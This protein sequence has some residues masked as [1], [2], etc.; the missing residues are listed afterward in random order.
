MTIYIAKHYW[1]DGETATWEC[2]P[3]IDKNLF[4]YL[5]ENYS[6]LIKD[7]PKN[8]QVS[9]RFI[10]LCYEET[11]DTFG[12]NITNVTFFVM[13][14]Q[15]SIDFCSSVYSNLEITIKE[16]KIKT[17]I[18]LG[19]IFLSLVG[20]YNYFPNANT[21]SRSKIVP[22]EINASDINNDEVHRLT[23]KIKKDEKIKEMFNQK[24]ALKL[25]E[26]NMTIRSKRDFDKINKIWMDI[27]PKLKEKLRLLS[28]ENRDKISNLKKTI[29]TYS[30]IFRNGVKCTLS[31]EKS[32]SQILVKT[33]HEKEYTYNKHKFEINDIELIKL[34]HNE[35]LF[36][37]IASDYR[38]KIK[39]IN[40]GDSNGN[41]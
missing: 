25:N 23:I 16:S 27:K 40:T 4:K 7:K 35:V 18:L 8:I 3:K 9:K 28:D 2:H 14:K 19:V 36:K 38:I 5:K 6:I 20:I 39:K 22:S 1:K 34:Y 33:L 32:N 12:R 30:S 29:S 15:L 17:F 10:H 41:E 31:K 24:I 13:K 26:C 37:E 11:I 21:P